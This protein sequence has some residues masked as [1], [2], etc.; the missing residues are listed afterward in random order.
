MTAASGIPVDRLIDNDPELI[1]LMFVYGRDASRAGFRTVMPMSVGGEVSAASLCA[2]TSGD[3]FVQRCGPF[4]VDHYT[5][6]MWFPIKDF[7]V[8]VLPPR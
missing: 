7:D 4:R 1:Q 8:R 5:A 6:P 2:T 3:E